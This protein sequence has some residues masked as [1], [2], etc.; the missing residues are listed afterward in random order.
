MDKNNNGKIVLYGATWCA[1]CA[2]SKAYLDS[3]GVEYEYINLEEDVTAAAKVT[4]INHGMQSIPTIVFPDGNILVEPSDEQLGEE[5][6]QLM[7]NNW[8]VAGK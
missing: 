2:R 6:D 5:L 7:A 1:D 3:R 8:K 4:E